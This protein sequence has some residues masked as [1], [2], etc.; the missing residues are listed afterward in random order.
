MRLVCDRDVDALFVLFLGRLPESAQIYREN[1]GQDVLD[2]ADAI[3]ESEE[4]AQILDNF[5]TR[6]TLPHAQLGA[7]VFDEAIATAVAIGLAPPELLDLHPGPCDADGLAEREGDEFLEAAYRVILRRDADAEGLAHYRAVL[8]G[9][10]QSKHEII[11][12]FLASEEADAIA[13]EPRSVHSAAEGA[14]APDWFA[15]LAGVFAAAPLAGLIEAHHGAAGREFVERLRMP[16]RPQPIP[17]EDEQGAG[18]S[19]I[20][21]SPEPLD[22]AV[23]LPAQRSLWING[24]TMARD[25][26]DALDVFIDGAPLG[27][28]A[29]GLSRPDVAAEF[30][31]WPGAARSGFTALIPRRILRKGHHDVEIALRDTVGR[32][33]TTAFAVDVA[34]SAADPLSIRQKIAQAEIDLDHRILAKCGWRPAFTLL[35]LTGTGEDA[36]AQARL[37]LSSLSRQAYGDWRV[38]VAPSRRGTGSDT[39]RERLVDGSETVGTL[40]ARLPDN[41]TDPA[42]LRSRLLAG[43]EDIAG[44]VEILESGDCRSLA[45]LAGNGPALFGLVAA[46]DELSADAFIEFAV[47]GALHR[48][49]DFLY[50]DEWRI[51][52]ASGEAEPFLKPQ[53]SP[54]LLLATNYI[55]R[56]WCAAPRLLAETGATL[57][58]L[59]RFGEYDLVLRLTEAAGRI[60]HVPELLCR[61][62]EQRLDAAAERQALARAMVRR[63]VRGTLAEGC[64]SGTYRLKRALTR[65]G[66]VSIILCT[67]AARGLLKNC[68]ETLRALTAYRPFEIIVVENV[69]PEE[70]HWREWLRANADRVI[71]PN[72]P[73][74]WSRF[75]NL[76][77]AAAS[78]EYLLFLNDGIE[79]IEPDWLDALIEHGQRPEVGAVGARLLDP[80]RTVRHAGMFLTDRI[81]VAGHAFRNL[82]EHDPGYFGLARTQRNVIAVTGACLLTRAEIFKR[83]GGFNE[84]H[85]VINNDLDY[86]LKSW[87]SGLLNVFTPYATLIHHGDSPRSTVIGDCDAGAFAG[88]WRTVFHDGDPYYHRC[89]SRETDR[90]APE[91]EPLRLICPAAPLL[92]R[93]TIRSILVVKLDHIGDGITAFPAIRRLKQQFPDARLCLLAGRWTRPIW[94]FAGVIDEV[95]EFDFFHARSSLGLREV[96]LA[97][98]AA[99]HERLAPYRFDLAVDLRKHP[100]TR[101]VLQYVGARYLAGFDSDRRFPWLDIAIDWTSDRPMTPRPQ[102]VRS[103]L[104]ALV[105]AIAA[106]CEPA[107]PVVALPDADSLPLIPPMQRRLFSR[108]LVCV[109]PAA[110]D[111]LKQWPSEYF[112]EL[113]ELLIEKEGVNV[114]LV[115]GPDDR[116]IAA[117]VLRGVRH[118]HAVTDL[119]GCLK[120]DD[121][122]RL[123][124]RCALFVGNDSGPKHIASGLGVPT[125]GVHSGLVD[126]REWGPVGPYGI[127]LQRDM[128]CGP[129]YLSSLDLCPRDLACLT[130]LRPGEVYHACHRLLALGLGDRPPESPAAISLPSARPRRDAPSRIGPTDP[131]ARGDRR[132][133]VAESSSA[134]GDAHQIRCSAFTIVSR[135]YIAYAATLMQSLAAH[136]PE[137]ARYVFLADEPYDFSDVELPAQIVCCKELGIPQF[138]EMTFRYSIMELNTAVKPFCIQWL[139][140][141]GKHDKVIYLDPDIFVLRPLAAVVD[142]L[143]RGAPLILTP[144]ITEPLQDGFKPD[145]MGVM[146]AGVYNLGFGAFARSAATEKL[147]AWWAARLTRHCLVDFPNHLFTDQRWMDLAPGFVP[148]T[149]ILRHPGYNA[150]YWNL[151]H[152]PVT[153]D[154]GGMWRAAGEPLHFFHFSGIDPMKPGAFSKHQDRFSLDATG[155]LR[156]LVETYL[157]RLLANGYLKYIKAPYAYG[158]FADG[159]PIHPLMRGCFRRLEEDGVALPG[160]WRAGGSAIFDQIEPGLRQA[161]LPDIT[162]LMYQLWLER[163]DLRD[164]FDL[165][166]AEERLAF[167][168]WFA[169]QAQLEM[170]IDGFSLNA[171]A[172]LAET[173]AAAQ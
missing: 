8:A 32:R 111:P 11:R 48:E 110:G 168:E 94:G 93:E 43:F 81:G 89:F 169:E 125:V 122:P 129:C 97:E 143:D 34:E 105:D 160:L 15:A 12:D 99:L 100:E 91:A 58:D 158:M 140:R 66:L 102:P 65:P 154:P 120:L 82:P 38:L 19:I 20:L 27:S 35:L 18:L 86:C 84:A 138:P 1:R 166:E 141:E 36:I 144:H 50:S 167:H 149:A 96:G 28:V 136:H 53:W 23:T 112:A 68:L 9:G 148:D 30:P 79:I 128:E 132:P 134:A 92:T 155:G 164:A 10:A 170:G 101:P 26:V 133:S 137:M 123:M 6:G 45:G 14:V 139:F 108:P 163:D 67:R 21:D 62:G 74:N 2:A 147:V 118:H 113:I 172:A 25:G 152:R 173:D 70:V 165:D 78:G 59:L 44:R 131:L 124:V 126:A 52:P 47:T 98:F 76:G 31:D 142:L 40:L 54:D 29:H 51:S 17:E 64:L 60:C 49:A 75:N 156:P 22:D 88:Q 150:A 69:P 77:A 90:L 117:E 55:G 4:F 115:G 107:S 80:D 116:D 161:G 146:Q 5:Q 151:A 157:N 109:H 16:P 130:G 13:R 95:I 121:L 73:F 71:T 42:A 56:F 145:D 103:S 37:T 83:L 159:R 72:E 153:R 57:A 3:L 46:G 61:R 7:E 162:R 114:A 33:R 106:S 87:K 39:L 135:N 85:N 63:G 127:A 119:V 41:R 171:A 104:V 24:W